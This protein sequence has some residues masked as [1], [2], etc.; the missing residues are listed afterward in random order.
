[1][2]TQLTQWISDYDNGQIMQSVDMGGMGAGY[3]KAIQSCAVEIMRNLAG[4][5]VPEEIEE[6]REILGGSVNEAVAKLNKE[7][8]FSGAQAGAAQNLAAIFWRKSPEGG[9]KSMQDID[10]SRVM[11][12][13]KGIDGNVELIDYKED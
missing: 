10:P 11:K 9:I 7:F 1:M 4:K 2:S 3:E 6:F 8:G 5:E 13:K 12:I